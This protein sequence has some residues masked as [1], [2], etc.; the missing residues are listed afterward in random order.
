MAELERVVEALEKGEVP[1]EQS[2]SLYERG[3]RLKAHCEAK[4]KAAEERVERLTLDGQGQPQG[5]SP[6]TRNE[7]ACVG[8]VA[9]RRGIDP[10]RRPRPSSRRSASAAFPDE[11]RCPSCGLCGAIERGWRRRSP[12]CPPRRC[13]TRWR[14]RRGRQAPA[15]VP[16]DG[17]RGAA[18]RRRCRLG[19]GGGGDRGDACLLAG[20][21][22]PARHGRRRPA[23]GPARRCTVPGTRRRRSW[24]ATRC[25]RW[26]SSWRW[27]HPDADVARD[28]GVG[29]RGRRAPPG[30]C[31]GRR[32]TSR[33]RPR[34][35][36]PLARRSR[37]C[38]RARPGR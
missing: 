4:L 14:M 33:R 18:R 20:P 17:G 32:R 1:L 3:A 30:W 22:R 21:R 34:P 26:R 29:W 5:P 11:F 6:S 35:P 25:R 9:R 27:T 10:A 12:R 23:P 24:P 28:L 13:A 15:R 37:R 19:D 38:R 8:K 16:G 7:A 36:L 2:I 31:W